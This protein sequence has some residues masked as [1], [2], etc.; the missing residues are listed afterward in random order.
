MRVWIRE[1]F[2]YGT[3]YK[4]TPGRLKE[5]QTEEKAFPSAATAAAAAFEGLLLSWFFLPNQRHLRCCRCSLWCHSAA[6]QRMR[7]SKLLTFLL[8]HLVWLDLEYQNSKLGAAGRQ[9]QILKSF[10]FLAKEFR[11]YPEASVATLEEMINI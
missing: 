5:S 7:L 6:G 10:E 8:W 9:N 11:Y 1:H 2:H 4:H 3:G